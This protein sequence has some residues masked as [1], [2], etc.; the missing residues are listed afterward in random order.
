MFTRLMADDPAFHVVSAT[1]EEEAIGIAV[2]SYAV[3]RQL[4]RLHAVQRL[5]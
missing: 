4:R 5:R 1:R 3:G 2:G